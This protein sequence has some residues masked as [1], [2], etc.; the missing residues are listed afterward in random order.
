MT[1]LLVATRN[2]GKLAEFAAALAG[3][4]SFELLTLD[5]VPTMADVDED[6][7][8]LEANAEK[9][10][11]E[12]GRAARLLTLADDSGLEVDALHGAPGVMSA[13]F[14][15]RHGDDAANNAKLLEA[16]RGTVGDARSAR[17]RCVLAL[18]EP[19]TE[20]VSFATG[21]VEGH[22]ATAPRGA[23]GFGYDPLFVPRGGTRTMA[24]LSPDEKL[25]LS[26]R[27]RALEALRPTLA[28]RLA[29]RLARS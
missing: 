18:F 17:F 5:D 8:T 9:K 23:L 16:L 15:G 14:A 29:E 19:E 4:H 6:R 21:T 3:T 10:A 24:E 13:R 1:R 22:I 27:G 20:G 7:D 26:H 2:R 11:Q 12:Y 25:A 28:Q